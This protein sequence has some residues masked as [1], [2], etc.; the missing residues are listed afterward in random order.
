MM[1]N[2]PHRQK[3]KD[4]ISR[5]STATL[6]MLAPGVIDDKDRAAIEK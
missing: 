3:L 1:E 2:Q 6:A 4:S 5:L